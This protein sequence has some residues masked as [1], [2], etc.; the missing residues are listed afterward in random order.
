MGVSKSKIE[1]YTLRVSERESKPCPAIIKQPS[2]QK[3]LS[4]LS[5]QSSFVKPPELIST[6]QS[7]FLGKSKIHCED[8]PVLKK[9]VSFSG[10]RNIACSNDAPWLIKSADFF[11]A[12]LD[13]FELSN[14]IGIEFNINSYVLIVLLC[15]TCVFRGWINGNCSSC[16]Y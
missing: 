3:Q 8:Q 10:L 1:T 16:Q 13:C 2:M 14:V 12:A 7:S 5:K 9:A 4:N 11:G 15:S 6:K